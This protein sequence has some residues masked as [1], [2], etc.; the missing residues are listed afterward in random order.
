MQPYESNSEETRDDASNAAAFIVVSHEGQHQLVEFGERREIVVG[1][2]AS[3]DC[4]LTL[5]GVAPRHCVIGWS[6]RQLVVTP[7][8]GARTHRGGRPVEEPMRLDPGDD[9]TIGPVEIVIGIRVVPEL[10]RRRALTHAELRE[11]LV[12]DLARSERVGRTIALLSIRCSFGQGARVSRIASESLRTGDMLAS[13]GP[14]EI[15]IALADANDT[16][17]GVVVDRISSNGQIPLNIGYAIA[18]F[19]A[20]DADE[21]LAASHRALDEAIRDGASLGRAREVPCVGHEPLTQDDV[22]REL[23]TRVNALA[24]GDGNIILVG[25]RS[26]GRA[27]LGRFIHQRSGRSPER[28]AAISSRHAS[29][30]RAIN[31][32]VKEAVGGTLVVRDIDD[33]SLDGQAVLREAISAM[34]P[35]RIVTTT[36]RALTALVERGVVD[37]SLYR[38]LEGTRVEVPPLRS[39]PNDLV[40]FAEHFARQHGAYEPTRFSVGAFARLHAYPWSGNLVELDD[41]MRR[42]TQLAGAGEILAE[43]LPSEPIPA[44][45]A[46]GRL[47][48]HVDSV[49][50]DAIIRA[51]ADC[52]QNQTHSAR[53]LGLSRRALIYKMEKYGLKAPAG[54][55]P[56]RSSSLPVR[57]SSKPVRVA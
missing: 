23:A 47:R 26:S 50:R 49:E 44:D 48:E 19:D 11:R 9:L 33:W 53:K 18:P 21:L 14:D 38:L 42:A 37:A 3:C 7:V 10:R 1:S 22:S 51:L 32:R 29:D 52:N 45:A 13:H 39:R 36:S 8:T 20:D 2:D 12:E 57:R 54:T 46:A 25:E 31:V 28:F 16:E 55:A 17:V 30:A 41:A 43:H 34:K 35:A 40:A 56:R 24:P 5:P 27:T 6:G 15:E 4:R